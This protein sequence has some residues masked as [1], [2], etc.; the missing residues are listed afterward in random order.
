[1]TDAS[2]W[3]GYRIDCDV[4]DDTLIVKHLSSWAKEGHGS[5]VIKRW[6]FLR[7]S[8]TCQHIR[9][10]LQTANRESC[11]SWHRKNLQAYFCSESN[12]L[13]VSK[14]P[15]DRRKHAFGDNIES[16]LAELIHVRTCFLSI[17][18]MSWLVASNRQAKKWMIVT[19]AAAVLIRHA[20]PKQDIEKLLNRWRDFAVR[21]ARPSGFEVRS[22]HQESRK[23]SAEIVESIVRRMEPELKRNGVFREIVGLIGR[24]RRGGHTGEFVAV[25]ALHFFC[26]QMGLTIHQEF[27]L[28]ES[29]IDLLCPD[30]HPT[31]SPEPGIERRNT[32]GGQ[33]I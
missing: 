7:Y 24:V 11:S 4:F 1:M 2:Q 10:R 8:D 32:F 28:T 26:N 31:G 19:G 12:C 13:V 21:S 3:F 20:I 23:R 22:L 17:G 18:L 30:I 16:V 15:Y 27:G 14:F 9:V 5:G 25:H 33:L 29:L 6:F